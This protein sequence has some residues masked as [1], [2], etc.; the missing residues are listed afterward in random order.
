MFFDELDQFL[1]GFRTRNFAR[2]EEKN[3]QEE[4]DIIDELLDLYLLAWWEGS[5]D[6]ARELL[7]D[8]EPSIEEAE[9]AINRPIADKTFRERVRDYLNGEMGETTGTPSEAIA[10]VA[11]T[12]AVRLYNES[13]I[14]TA[15]KGG[16]TKKTWHTMGDNRVRDTHSPLQGQTV[17]IDADF[18]TWDDD[19][20]PAPGQFLKTSNNVNCR[21]WLTFSK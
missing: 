5:Q 19:Q 9:E 12:D 14:K 7:I 11:E 1:V 8:V 3:P 2:S 15:K 17:P 10:R 16:A 4:E 13:G 18:Y 6:A 20:A 21:C